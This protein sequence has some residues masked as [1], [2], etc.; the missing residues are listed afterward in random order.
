MTQ[1]SF[2]LVVL[3][4][5]NGSNLQAIIDQCASGQI[6]AEVTGVISSSASAFGLQRAADADIPALT[7]SPSDYASREEHDVALAAAIDNWQPDA[8]ILAGY[9]RILSADFVRHYQGR[10]LNIHPSLLPKY[11]GLNTHQRAIEA[12][13]QEHGASVH[14]VTEELDGGPVVLQGK[15]PVFAEDTPESL[16]QRVHD[17]EHRI[18]PM[19]INWLATGRLEAEANQVKLD[20]ELLPTCG[21][22]AE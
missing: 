13:E 5:G 18:Y 6:Q 15:V 12:G 9:M 22:A 19:V 20:G 1:S 10:M 11:T 3:I 2:K 7:I 21:Y 14:F 4:S 17:Q 8:V 16:S